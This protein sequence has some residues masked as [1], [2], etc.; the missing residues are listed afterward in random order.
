MQASAKRRYYQNQ[1]PRRL[2][3]TSAAHHSEFLRT[4]R[5]DR[6]APT[7]DRE[8]KRYLSFEEVA[9]RT[10]RKLVRAGET[11]HER[12]NAFHEAIRFPKVIFSRAFEEIPHLGYCHVTTAS[13][14]FAQ[15]GPVHW[16]FY[17]ANF[18]SDISESYPFFE[19]IRSGNVR[20]YFAVAYEKAA[21]DTLRID[22]SMRKDC[23][24]FRTANPREAM[25]NLLLLGAP[26]QSL[27]TMIKKL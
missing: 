25:K 27:R 8:T 24:L 7:W 17:I 14:R 18:S 12:L 9:E 20:M 19:N 3:A 16:S 22:R 10:N 11:T 26:S 23:L 5:I 1:A 2:S 13:T 21:G 15:R 4:G 6:T